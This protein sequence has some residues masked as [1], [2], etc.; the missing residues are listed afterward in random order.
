MSHCG[1]AA[2]SDMWT[3]KDVALF[4]LMEQ[5][6]GDSRSHPWDY[7]IVSNAVHM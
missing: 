4:I 7:R 1:I 2:K 6:R 5:R 3:Y